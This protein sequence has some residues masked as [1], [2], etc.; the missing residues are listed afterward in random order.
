VAYVF[1][2][3]AEQLARQQMA[4]NRVRESSTGRVK[5]HT[6]LGQILGHVI[7]HELGHL[8][9]LP[10]HSQTGIMRADWDLTDLQDIAYGHLL[11]T[12]QQSNTI[13]AEV[14]RRTLRQ[15]SMHGQSAGNTAK[16]E[17]INQQVYPASSDH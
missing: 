11:F 2:E 16:A 5:A 1:Y 6:E 4:E 7:A 3:R 10:S 13:R 8:L 12:S 17:L 14:S 9:G 15:E